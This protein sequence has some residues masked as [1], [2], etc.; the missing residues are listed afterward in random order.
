[1]VSK[2]ISQETFDEVVKENVEDF[3]MSP[4]DALADA[5]NQFQKQGIDLSNVD[6]TGGIGRQEVLDALALLKHLTESSSKKEDEEEEKELIGILE[7]LKKLCARNYILSDRNIM[8]M[9]EQGGVN[10]LHLLLNDKKYSRKV[11]SSAID[12]L[13]DL[14]TI[15]VPTRDFFEPGGSSRLCDLLKDQTLND[16]TPSSSIE[17]LLAI[18]S[19]ARCVMRSEANKTALMKAGFGT[20]L[21]SLLASSSNNLNTQI[22]PV[23]DKIC[24]CIRGLCIHDDLRREMS[25]AFDNAKFFLKAKDVVVRLMGLAAG[26][27]Q[28]PN[29]AC[30]A[31]NAAK[32]LASTNEAVQ[33]LCIHGAVDAVFNILN[34]PHSEDKTSLA[35]MRSAVGLLRN[36]AAD[37]GKK[38]AFLST[39]GLHALLRIVSCEPYNQDAA[40]LEHAMACFAQFT[41]RSPSQSERLVQ[42][43]AV[44][45]IIRI[46]RSFAQKDLLQRQACLT[47]RNIA[48]RCPDLRPILLDAGAEAVLRAAG[49]MPTVVDEAYAALRDLNCE[50]QYV[51]IDVDGSVKPV[52]EQFGASGKLNFRPVYDDKTD[53]E[54]KVAENARAPF[55]L[56]EEDGCDHDH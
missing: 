25:S 2:R 42:A 44:D 12:F 48:G 51:K 11:I 23:V 34:H 53:I 16:E 47:L 29:L 3:D 24:T 28:L 40:L 17:Y 54:Q 14:S 21:T 18:L 7:E 41:L 32:A 27:E 49:M 13:T 55:A 15:S 52:Y 31:L 20:I 9:K 35:L 19:L 6:L 45:V 1:M 43:G 10:S 26:Y 5:I 39:G 36:I 56:C 4:G 50:V 37:D 22:V 30:A 46:M 38:E 33:L 8:L